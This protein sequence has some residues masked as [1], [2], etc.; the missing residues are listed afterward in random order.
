MVAVVAVTTCAVSLFKP[1]KVGT[2]D[3]STACPTILFTKKSTNDDNTIVD[4]IEIDE[5]L[6]V[7]K[8]ATMSSFSLQSSLVTTKK[9]ALPA[10]N[11]SRTQKPM[12]GTTTLIDTASSISAAMEY[13]LL[14]ANSNLALVEVSNADNSKTLSNCLDTKNNENISTVPSSSSSSSS[15]SLL[16]LLLSSSSSW[17]SSNNNISLIWLNIILPNQTQQLKERNIL[18]CS[19]DYVKPLPMIQ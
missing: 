10:D 5:A 9:K 2:C 14:L 11:S 16:L 8:T 4:D 18:C 12:T 19:S 6:T 3:P 15:S 7:L 17:L 13:N 1:Q